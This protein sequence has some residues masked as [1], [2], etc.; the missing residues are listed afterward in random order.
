MS[1]ERE[2]CKRMEGSANYGND[3]AAS[4]LLRKLLRFFLIKLNRTTEEGYL[5]PVSSDLGLLWFK[6]E[7]STCSLHAQRGAKEDLGGA[8][9][10]VGL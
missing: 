4:A 9:K 1:N 5:D 3:E 2:Q 7:E 6:Q 8:A 10:Q